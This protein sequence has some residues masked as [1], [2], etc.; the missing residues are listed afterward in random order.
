MQVRD[1]PIWRQPRHHLDA[2]GASDH[3]H[4]V[5]PFFDLV[6]V[7]TLAWIYFD[8]AGNAG[9]K[10]TTLPILL[11]YWLGHIVL[12]WSIVLIGVALV[13]EFHVGLLE[14]YPN[15]YGTI[16]CL[17]LAI[18]LATLWGLQLLV[19]GRD[20]TRRNHHGRL[21]LFGVFT[22]LLLL[23]SLPHVPAIVGNLIWGTALFAQIGVPLWKAVADLRAE[24]SG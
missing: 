2:E 15:D 7:V 22:A 5:E 4:W 11:S 10:G 6:H 12:M 20:A 16:G 18:F 21:C 8:S 3:V 23:P 17:G 1:F 13:G 24:A 14:P 9:P 19:E